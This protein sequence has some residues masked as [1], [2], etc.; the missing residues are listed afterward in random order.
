MK[1]NYGKAFDIKIKNLTAA[2]KSFNKVTCIKNHFKMSADSVK[3]TNTKLISQ[4]IC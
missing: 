3:M 2:M 4:K 1:L